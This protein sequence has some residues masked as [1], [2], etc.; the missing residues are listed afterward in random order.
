MVQGTAHRPYVYRTLLPTLVRQI[1][2]LTPQQYRDDY[3]N[4]LTRYN[5]V[6]QKLGWEPSAVFEYT[7]ALILMLACFA[8]FAHYGTKFT[9]K[10]CGLGET[11]P[12]RMLL[13]TSLLLCLP[14]FFRYTSFIYDPPQ[15]LLFS[16]ALYFLSCSRLGAFI[17][18]FYF[19]CI[20]KETAILLIPIYA[21]MEYNNRLSTRRYRLILFALIAGYLFIKTGIS[22][23]FRTNP[24]VFLEFH[25]LDNIGLLTRGWSFT[26][27]VTLFIIILLVFYGWTEKPRFLQVSF[28]CL[29][30][31]L[32]AAAFLFGFVNEW[33]DYYE[34]Y[35]VVFAMIIDSLQRLNDRTACSKTDA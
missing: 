23:V 32:L 6:W 11:W 31:P 17:L 8:G 33:R 34:V 19:C 20:N 15:L 22:Y 7:I 29:F 10:I 35:P 27:L 4:K 14:A 3:N 21:V 13:A 12:N 16:M 24:G 2:G 30:P 18:T 25:L 26:D 5:A 28:L 9:I 1:T